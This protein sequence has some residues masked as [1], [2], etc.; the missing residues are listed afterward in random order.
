MQAGARALTLIQTISIT[1]SCQTIVSPRTWDHIVDFC[2]TIHRHRRSVGS[3][4]DHGSRVHESSFFQWSD[5]VPRVTSR[6]GDRHSQIYSSLP[7][8]TR[9]LSLVTHSLQ[10]E[11]PMTVGPKPSLP[12]HVLKWRARGIIDLAEEGWSSVTITTC[13]LLTKHQLDAFVDGVILSF[14][15]F[16]GV[17]STLS[18]ARILGL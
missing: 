10:Q 15:N 7:P 5:S 2:K 12:P 3:S 6:H 9:P 18:L 11:R 4:R 17:Q 16:K 1:I 14:L 13:C 8:T